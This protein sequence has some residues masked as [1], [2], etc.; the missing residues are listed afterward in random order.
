MYPDRASV[1][2]SLLN[3]IVCAFFIFCLIETRLSKR[4]GMDFVDVWQ[5]NFHFLEIWHPQQHIKGIHLKLF[6]TFTEIKLFKQFFWQTWRTTCTRLQHTSRTWGKK[7][8]SPQRGSRMCGIGAERR[9]PPCYD[10]L[11]VLVPQRDPGL[12]TYGATSN[13][14]VWTTIQSLNRPSIKNRC[15]TLRVE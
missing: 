9:H 11:Q 15:P 10:V 5:I 14:A 13:C 2:I 4:H 8:A 6:H 7:K 1:F 12:P 3:H